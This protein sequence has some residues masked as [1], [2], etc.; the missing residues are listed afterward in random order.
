MDI[1]GFNARSAR[2]R[3]RSWLSSSQAAVAASLLDAQ[4]RRAMWG[5]PPVRAAARATFGLLEGVGVI[6]AK[7]ESAQ[8]FMDAAR[9]N[10][11]LCVPVTAIF[12]RLLAASPT[13]LTLIQIA[14]RTGL[15]ELLVERLLD[16]HTA[17]VPVGD[18]WEL[19]RRL[20]RPRRARALGPPRIEP[21]ATPWPAVRA[22][23][24]PAASATTQL[25]PPRWPRMRCAQQVSPSSA[26]SLT[27]LP[28]RPIPW[29][30]VAVT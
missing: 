30:S 29:G 1:A 10:D 13:P 18:G 2:R 5:S 11:G 21:A 4:S 25:L 28:A 24:L 23:N 26:A 7:G 19:G 22:G 14:D 15:G 17:F 9:F 8:A 3:L 20:L 12:V 27:A 16:S 6:A